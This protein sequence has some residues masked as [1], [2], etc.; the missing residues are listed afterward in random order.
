MIRYD[1]DKLDSELI[2]M[3]RSNGVVSFVNKYNISKGVGK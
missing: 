2:Y 3:Y 1:W